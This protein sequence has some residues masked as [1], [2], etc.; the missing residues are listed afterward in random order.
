MNYNQQKRYDKIYN[1]EFYVLEHNDKDNFYQFIIS[2]STRSVYTVKIY[3]NNLPFCNCPDFCGHAKRAGVVCKHV[4]FILI[5]VLKYTNPN[6]FIDYKIDFNEI[7]NLYINLVLDQNLFNLSLTDKYFDQITNKPD[8]TKYREFNTDAECP[9]CYSTFKSQSG[10]LLGCP[11]C[12]NVVHKKCM[13]KWLTIKE[14]CS[15]CRS[16]IWKQYGDKN[17]Q[18]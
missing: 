9:I 17:L 11:T 3:K 18:L 5:K 16:E 4:C 14:S 2:G 13:E 12:L 8:F 1:E 6:Y 15:Y 10:S 7:K